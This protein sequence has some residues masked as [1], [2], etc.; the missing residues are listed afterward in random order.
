ML[1][2]SLVIRKKTGEEVEKIPKD[3]TKI[4]RTNTFK[5]FEQEIR[6]KFKISDKEITIKAL[7]SDKEEINIKDEESYNDEDY[8]SLTQYIVYIDIE[9]DNSN[10]TGDLN[11]EEILNIKNDLFIDEKEFKD[12]LDKQIDISKISQEI[13][14][15]EEEKEPKL[16]PEAQ[17]LEKFFKDFQE[18]IKSST[19]NNQESFIDYIKKEFTSFDKLI[20]D[21][22]ENIKI[23]I[24]NNIEEADNLE[25]DMHGMK[26][27]IPTVA[28]VLEK[29]PIMLNISLDKTKYEIFDNKAANI[30]I[31]NIKLKNMSNQKV[32]L[33]NKCWIKDK[34]NSDEDIIILNKN[35]FNKNENL[36]ENEE[37]TQNLNL[38]INNPKR[39]KTYNLKFYLGDNTNN[40]SVSEKVTSNTLTLSIKIKE[41]EIIQ[42]PKQ[43]Q[44][45]PVK[46][47]KKEEVKKEEIKKEEVKKEENPSINVGG[48]LTNEEVDVIYRILDEN[49]YISSIYDENE[50]KQ[51]IRE[52]NGTLEELKKYYEG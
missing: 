41:N 29:Q 51:K 15:D 32:S 28:N 36:D 43:Q 35:I 33:Q 27:C 23:Y 9:E 18:K 5:E 50:I 11:I 26:E 4:K 22:V 45:Q 10:D 39:N 44:I 17:L 49:Y 20:D 48:S 25:K 24:N 30:V 1:E 46:N 6:S 14:I 19:D 52:M 37:K 40:N 38:S 47:E 3:S 16:N 34:K 8:K 12:M 42:P 13:N 21:K 2:V 7:D 31:E